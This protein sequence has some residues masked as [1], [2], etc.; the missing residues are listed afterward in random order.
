VDKSPDNERDELWNL[1]GEARPKPVS[2]FFARNILRQIHQTA[3][4]RV[5]FLVRLAR[6]WRVALTTGVAVI[7]L[8]LAGR[9]WSHS[10]GSSDS[11]VAENEEIADDTDYEVINH[12]DELLAY[13]EDSVWLEKSVY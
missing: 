1:L 12:L 9:Q 8:A 13:E 11:V 6:S 2:P 7:A 3:P 5:G 4:D 10:P